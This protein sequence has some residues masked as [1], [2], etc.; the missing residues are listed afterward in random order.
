MMQM[1]LESKIVAT[2]TPGT[3]SVVCEEAFEV[4]GEA[5]HKCNRLFKGCLLIAIE[6]GK[7]LECCEKILAKMTTIHRVAIMLASSTIRSSREG[8]EDIYNLAYN[9]NVELFIIPQITF[10]IRARRIGRHEFT[11]IEAASFAGEAVRQKIKDVYGEYPRVDLKYPQVEIMLLIVEETAIIG[12]LLTDNISLHKRGYRVYKHPASLK[13]TIAH[14]MIR[15]AGV[16]DGDKV[17]DPMCG[18]GTIIIEAARRFNIKGYGMDLSPKHL[19]GAMLNAIA[20]GV[21]NKITFILGD[22]TKIDHYVSE[23]VDHIITNPPYGIRL[24]RRKIIPTLYKGLISSSSRVVRARGRL[25]IVTA[26]PRVVYDIL[27]G[28]PG[29]YKLVHRL[30]VMHGGLRAE[31][32]VLEK[33][34]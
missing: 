32:I 34:C 28:N 2:C 12:L 3:E 33:M 24:T 27:A 17:L 7:I 31:I 25:V 23:E 21:F 6:R 20:A 4:L 30:N 26:V 9:S 14:T 16:R 15:L 5:C 11:S 8:L 22:A 1:E 18:G 29:M 19:R 13:P 10:A